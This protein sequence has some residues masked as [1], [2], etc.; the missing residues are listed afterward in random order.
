MTF[1]PG[2]VTVESARVIGKTFS[3]SA[4]FGWQDIGKHGDAKKASEQE[5]N[6]QGHDQLQSG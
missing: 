6:S 1:T 4:R 2:I 3:H 5:K